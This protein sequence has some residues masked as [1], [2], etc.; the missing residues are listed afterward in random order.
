MNAEKQYKRVF[1][2]VVLP[3]RNVE[4]VSFVDNR[5]DSVTQAKLITLFR[6]RVV[7]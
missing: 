4:R 7:I 6:K 1:S 3:V 5:S 2:N